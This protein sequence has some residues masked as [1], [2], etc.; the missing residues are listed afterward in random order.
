MK[1]QEMHLR[2]LL[3]PGV[4][5]NLNLRLPE[6]DVNTR[7]KMTTVQVVE[8]QK[9]EK[10]TPQEAHSFKSHEIIGNTEKDH[11]EGWDI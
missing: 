8:M 11:A 4:N 6:T 5:S 10:I 1:S 9:N 3:I 7:G 2:S